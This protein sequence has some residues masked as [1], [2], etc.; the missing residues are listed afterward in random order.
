MVCLREVGVSYAQKTRSLF[1][2]LMAAIM[3]TLGVED[4]KMMEEFREGSQLMVLNFFP[5]CPQ[6]ELTLGMPPHSDFGF[7]TV[8]LQ[9][10]VNGL[11]IQHQGR[12]ATVNVAAGSL[13]VNVGDHLEVPRS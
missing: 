11:Q 9:D 13:L 5:P 7:L 4:A 2:E 1:V 10:G 8:V 12:W 6:P 3:E